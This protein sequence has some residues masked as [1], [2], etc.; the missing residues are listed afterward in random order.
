MP[1]HVHTTPNHQHQ[2]DFF[3]GPQNA[4]HHHWDAGFGRFVFDT[5]GGPDGPD[6]KDIHTGSGWGGGAAFTSRFS[7]ASNTGLQLA[8]EVHYHRVIGMSQ[9]AD[10]DLTSGPA[11][12]GTLAIPPGVSVNFIIRAH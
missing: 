11:G 4:D 6:A 10:R 5:T 8:G 2:L 1:A 3:S 9:G 12:G 7:F